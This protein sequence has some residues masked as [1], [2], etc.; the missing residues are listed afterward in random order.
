MSYVYNIVTPLRELTCHVGSHSATC[1]LT[2]LTFPP[3]PQPKLVLDLA[4]PGACQDLHAVHILDRLNV[5]RKEASRD[6]TAGYHYF[7][8]LLLLLLLLLSIAGLPRSTIAPL[9]RVQ[10]AAAHLVARLGP[11]NHVTPTLKDRH[12]L[13][14]E[15]RIV[16]KLCLLMHQVHT[17]SSAILSSQLRQRISR[18]HFASSSALRLQSTLRTP[19]HASQVWRTFVVVCWT[20]SLEQSAIITA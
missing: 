17:G 13:P 3:L 20:E 10:N 9:Q 16:F 7:S 6:A 2:E 19:A 12:W 18:H 5:I 1:H 4:T 11:R 14:V 15:Q 8:N